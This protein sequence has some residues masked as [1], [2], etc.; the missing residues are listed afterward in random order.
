MKKIFNKKNKLIYF[1]HASTTYTDKEV[2]KKI[3]PYFVDNFAN[4][5]S[6]YD[7]ARKVNGDINEA[8][9][10]I[11]EI[12]FTTPDTIF[13]TSGGTESNNLAIFGTAYAHEK[14]GK[15]IISVR[16]EHEA[17]LKPL[18]K[19]KKQGFEIEYLP[20]D[21]TG[22]INLKNL[23]KAIRPDTILVTIM[24]ANN[25]IGTINDIAEIGKIILKHRKQSG[26][27]YPIFH[28]DACQ[29]GTSLDLNVK[30]LHTDLM[31]LNSSKIY[32][33]KGAGILYKDRNITIEPQILGG[34]QESGLRA[35]TENIPAIIGM[36]EA[37]K[38]VQKN[39]DRENIRLRKLRDYMWNEIESKIKKV[40][41]NGPELTDKDHR[42]VNN[43]N[44]SFLDIEGEALLLYLNEKNIVCS[45]G[46]AC[47]S[48]SLDASHVL[49]ACGISHEEAHGSLRFTLGHCNQKS[50]ID[51]LMQYLPSIVEKLREISPV[52]IK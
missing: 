50:D 14:K 19:L 44:V 13:F 5:S 22:K 45:T 24:Y 42:L 35:G 8:R 15:H 52:N 32:G 12:L 37:L 33:P 48:L 36:A 30:K 28:T 2:F 46:S 7:I 6:I 10:E 21:K 18:E 47:N 38:K 39:K 3:K 17:V 4:P 20:V 29:A 23:Q 16:T 26:N 49:L 51:Y 11:A 41:L 31:T 43:L 25:E 27:N 34:H 40:K 1:D 9:R